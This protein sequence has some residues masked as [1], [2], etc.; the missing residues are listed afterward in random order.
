MKGNFQ[1]RYEKFAQKLELTYL[2]LSFCKTQKN[3]SG[4]NFRKL[5]KL[6]K[7]LTSDRSLQISKKSSNFKNFSPAAPIGTADTDT[8]FF[9]R[10]I[11]KTLAFSS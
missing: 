11:T 2:T 3:F 8:I 6:F 9:P 7:K 10:K 5:T 4:P 1:I